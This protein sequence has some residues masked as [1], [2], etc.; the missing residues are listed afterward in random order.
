MEASSG[1]QPQVESGEFP[2]F[3]ACPDEIN[4]GPMLLVPLQMREVQISQFAPS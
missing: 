3:L 2:R 1:D 4:F